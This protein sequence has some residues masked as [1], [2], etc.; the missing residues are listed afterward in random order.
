[1]AEP[2]DFEQFEEVPEEEFDFNQF[3]EVDEMSEPESKDVAESGD[4]L[5]DALVSFGRGASLGFSDELGG[6]VGAA[7]EK[8]SDLTG[9]GASEEDVL[10]NLSP[11]VREKIQNLGIDAS[12]PKENFQDL[13]DQYTKMQRQAQETAVDRSPATSTAAMIA[14]GLMGPGGVGAAGA[15]T[16]KGLMSLGARYGGAAGFGESEGGLGN[17]LEGAATGAAFGAATA[18]AL[19]GAKKLLDQVGR[20]K[21][22]AG[23]TD[24]GQLYSS[25]R[26]G[27]V[28]SENID[29]NLLKMKDVGGEITQD[30]LEK[31]GREAQAVRQ[32]LS[33]ASDAGATIDL[34]NLEAEVMS[35]LDP[36]EGTP[37]Y[38]AILKEFDKFKAKKLEEINLRKQAAGVQQ[39]PSDKVL[40]EGIEGVRAD[41]AFDLMKRIKK[42]ASPAGSKDSTERAIFAEVDDILKS[43]IEPFSENIRENYRNMSDLLGKFET[44]T[45]KSPQKFMSEK[46]ASSV[47]ERLQSLMLEASPQKGRG[48]TQLEDIVEGFIDPKTGKQFKGLRE[49]SPESTAKIEGTAAELAEKVRLGAKAGGEQE[50]RTVSPNIRQQILAQAGGGG[51]FISRGAEVA[52]TGVRKASQFTGDVVQAGKDMGLSLVPEAMQ[53]TA[54]RLASKGYGKFADMLRSAS[55]KSGPAKNA[56]IFS[57]MQTPGFRQAIREL[58]DA[59]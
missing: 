37:A 53:E 20:I 23:K 47:R 11:E 42:I 17:R 5:E 39:I 34:R 50:I 58:E 48:K 13:V 16:A 9:G 43:K 15:K 57:L 27:E 29:A 46:E 55:E 10:A 41:E 26:K 49:I 54:G 51:S 45:G 59:E 8:L 6:V 12:V 21:R 33:E 4:T 56:A 38:K 24:I 40:Q 18:G 25:A 2:F 28:L 44:I 52:G 30:L 3:E 35:E 36:L 31:S 19:P 1:M 14:G 32:G 22:A 7:S